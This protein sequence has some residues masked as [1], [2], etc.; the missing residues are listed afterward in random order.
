[1]GALISKIIPDGPAEK[2]DLKVGDIILEFNNK[3]ILN[4]S[5]LP[6]IVGSSKVGKRVDVKVLRSGKEMTIKF[7]V[8]KL[9][10]QMQI[11]AKR[12]ILA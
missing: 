1:M 10:D 8:G 3:K 6:P 2:S 9:P 12:I 7:K 4:S 5:D 11:Q